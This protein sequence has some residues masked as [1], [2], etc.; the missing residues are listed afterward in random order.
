MGRG[1]YKVSSS[2]RL[3]QKLGTW[4]E[5]SLYETFLKQ[6]LNKVKQSMDDSMESQFSENTDTDTHTR[7]RARSMVTNGC[8]ML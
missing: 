8:A 5:K 3:A 1:A 6:Q 7:A 4:P 2:G